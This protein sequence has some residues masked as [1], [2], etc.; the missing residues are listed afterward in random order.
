MISFFKKGRFFGFQVELHS[1]KPLSPKCG[2]EEP[3]YTTGDQSLAEAMWMG[4]AFLVLSGL[5]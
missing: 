1:P 5:L 2:C 3:V 4:K